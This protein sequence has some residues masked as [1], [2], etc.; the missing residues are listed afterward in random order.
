MDKEKAERLFKKEFHE[1]T[2]G[3]FN[4]KGTG[5]GLVLCKEFVETNGGKIQVQSQPDH[6]SQFS[7]TLL[8]Q[9]WHSNEPTTTHKHNNIS[10]GFTEIRK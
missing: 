7:F 8:K 9:N 4:E 6:G 2:R 5:L 3:T 1:S 10:K